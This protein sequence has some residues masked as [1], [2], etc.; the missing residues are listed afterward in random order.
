MKS[1]NR[2]QFLRTSAPALSLATLPRAQQNGPK[3]SESARLDALGMGRRT[4][5]GSSKL[6]LTP[7]PSKLS[8]CATWTGAC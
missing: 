2:R 1:L 3:R 5:F 8:R 6:R 4:Y 7:L